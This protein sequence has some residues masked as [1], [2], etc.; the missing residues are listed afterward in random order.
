M[1]HYIHLKTVVSTALRE[2]EQRGPAID[3][4]EECGYDAIAAHLRGAAKQAK[5][6]LA[7]IHQDLFFRWWADAFERLAY[8]S[9]FE[10]DW[11]GSEPFRELDKLVREYEADQAEVR[12]HYGIPR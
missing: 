1:Q 3:Y 5:D 7:L 11:P 2:H 6:S 9:R 10:P 8:K 4:L 12:E